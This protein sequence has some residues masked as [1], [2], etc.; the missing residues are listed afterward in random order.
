MKHNEKE[1]KVDSSKETTENV[2]GL[3]PQGSVIS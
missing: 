1:K 2:G 3:A